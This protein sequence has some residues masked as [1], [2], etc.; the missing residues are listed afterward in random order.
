MRWQLL[1]A[2]LALVPQ[3]RVT[4]AFYAWPFAG[5][6][7]VWGSFLGIY[8]GKSLRVAKGRT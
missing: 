5:L 4:E 7:F 1:W 3:R 2:S 6:N 8:L